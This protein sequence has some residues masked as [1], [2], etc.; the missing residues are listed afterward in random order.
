MVLTPDRA[1]ASNSETQHTSASSAAPIYVCLSVDKKLLAKGKTKKVR[2]A[3]HD[4]LD[5]EEEI[6][7]NPFSVKVWIPDDERKVERMDKATQGSIFAG[8]ELPFTLNKAWRISLTSGDQTECDWRQKGQETAKRFASIS[9][10]VDAQDFRYKP[11]G[12][13]L[14]DWP[15][16]TEKTLLAIS[17]DAATKEQ[18]MHKAVSILA[19]CQVPG[20]TQLDYEHLV[21]NWF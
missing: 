7:K 18:F 21:S 9:D 14:M 16:E 17:S 12:Y 5:D 19:E 1:M 6:V 11:A 8:S 2:Q 13:R 4:N 3:L 10:R 20:L 15:D